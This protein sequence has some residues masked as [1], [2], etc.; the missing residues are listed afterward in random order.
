M[1]SNTGVC[2]LTYTI[3]TQNFHLLVIFALYTSQE[4]YGGTREQKYSAF[5][6]NVSYDPLFGRIDSRDRG[7][8]FIQQECYRSFQ[9]TGTGIAVFSDERV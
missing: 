9:F 8:G 1:N 7:S 5:V 3:C 2:T 4:S 6:G